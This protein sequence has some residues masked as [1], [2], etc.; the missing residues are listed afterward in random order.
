MTDHRPRRFVP[1]FVHT[2][3]RAHILTTASGHPM[4]GNP[5]APDGRSGRG[6][7]SVCEVCLRAVRV[8][9]RRCGPGEGQALRALIEGSQ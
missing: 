8:H 2:R 4:C 5:W 1:R 7:K 6:G 9:L 3:R